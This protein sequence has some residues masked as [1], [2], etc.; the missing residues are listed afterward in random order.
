MKC[1]TLCRGRRRRCHFDVVV[2]TSRCVRE[3]SPLRLSPVTLRVDPVICALVGYAYWDGLAW[4][5]GAAHTGQ[6]YELL[7]RRGLALPPEK[8]R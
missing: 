2:L 4:A 8:L 5:L 1:C 3:A 7:L 6:A